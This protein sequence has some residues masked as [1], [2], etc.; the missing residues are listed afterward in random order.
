MKGSISILN[1]DILLVELVSDRPFFIVFFEQITINVLHWN[2]NT[3]LQ[4]W[5]INATQLIVLWSIEFVPNVKLLN[6][7]NHHKIEQNYAPN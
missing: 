5:Y 3:L 7:L 1:I 4:L 2:I 6:I